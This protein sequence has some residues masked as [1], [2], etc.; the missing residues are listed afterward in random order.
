MGYVK[1]SSSDIEISNPYDALIDLDNAD[2]NSHE[3]AFIDNGHY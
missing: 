3:S 1:S 2:D